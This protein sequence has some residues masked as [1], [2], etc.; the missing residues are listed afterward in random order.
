MAQITMI[1]GAITANGMCRMAAH[2]GTV[3]STTIRPTTLPRYIEAIRPQTKILL[4]D[5]QHRPRLQAPDQPAQQHRGVRQNRECRASASAAAPST[6]ACA[7]VSG[8]TTPSIAALPNC[9]GCFGNAA[10]RRSP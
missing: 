10:P 2:Q 9:C 4:L 7:A 5:E 1:T 3:V 6:A 8:A